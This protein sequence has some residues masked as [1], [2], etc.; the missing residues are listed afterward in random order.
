MNFHI[1]LL[2]NTFWQSKAADCMHAAVWMNIEIINSKTDASVGT[3]DNFQMTGAHRKLPRGD[4]NV[5]SL[6]IGGNYLDARI[7]TVPYT[8]KSY[9]L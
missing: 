3:V 4:G 7:C 5:P 9:A 8:L 1:F 2:R 6:E